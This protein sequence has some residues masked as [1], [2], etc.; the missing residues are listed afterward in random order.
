MSVS[1]YDVIADQNTSISDINVAEGCLP[2]NVNNAIRQ[3]MADIA[4]EHADVTAKIESALKQISD[5]SGNLDK[6][7]VPKGTIALWS[8]AT[9]N[10]PTGWA[11]C[12]GQGGTKDL[13]NRFVVGAGDGYKANDT[14]GNASVTPSGSI[15]VS[16]GSHVLS[17]NEM[18]SHNH[19]VS[20]QGAHGGSWYNGGGWLTTI[21]SHDW[22]NYNVY[23][24]NSGASW[25]HNHSARGSYTG[26][27]FDNRPPFYAL[28]FIQKV[29]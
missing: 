11:L 3:L 16:V 18:P 24:S 26:N 6:H 4:Q 5:V 29:V 28:C 21:N 19:R 10:I 14:G 27:R 20:Q 23:S 2:S 7:K 12:N 15:S 22:G 25:G 17:W 9:S 13:R 1:D 8:G